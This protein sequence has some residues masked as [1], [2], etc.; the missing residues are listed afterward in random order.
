MYAERYVDYTYVE[1]HRAFTLLY[2]YL[3]EFQRI[4]VEVEI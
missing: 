4:Y 1:V 2:I 3:E